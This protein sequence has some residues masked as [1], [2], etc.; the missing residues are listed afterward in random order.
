MESVSVRC[1]DVESER[2]ACGVEP[3]VGRRLVL[4]GGISLVI[5]RLFEPRSAVAQTTEG[6]RLRARCD[7]VLDGRIRAGSR[8]HHDGNLQGHA[9]GL[10]DASFPHVMRAL[11]DF[12]VFERI[13]PSVRQVRVLSR[14]RGRGRLELRGD[15]P[16]VGG[17]LIP[18]N[19]RILGHT[20]G[21]HSLTLDSSDRNRPMR[22]RIVL[23]RTPGRVRTIVGASIELDPRTLPAI[24]AS[25]IHRNAAIG[26]IASL[27]RELH[28]RGH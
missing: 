7:S 20:D 17:Y 23:S 22:V 21:T 28:R 18:A 4:A 8:R 11:C 16:L 27:R 5:A 13:L 2:I 6:D 1:S 26:T 10:V 15:A 9:F 3:R 14:E 25:R 24:G 12:T 19:A